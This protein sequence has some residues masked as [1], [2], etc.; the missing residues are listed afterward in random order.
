M[1]RARSPQAGVT[2]LEMLLALAVSSMIGLASFILLD[3]VT[4]TE[5]GAAGELGLLAQRDR[6]FRLL[7]L[8]LAG[9]VSADLQE[10]TELVLN[11]GADRRTWRASQEG[12]ERQ[13]AGVDG[14][15]LS[16]RLSLEPSEFE[17]RGS[18]LVSLRLS[19]PDIWRVFALAEKNPR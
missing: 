1:T 9:A 7:A 2:L 11:M 6:M 3:G 18:G 15:I 16:Q 5:A 14:R 19:G 8:D 13:V 4:R 12:V 10:G 17:I